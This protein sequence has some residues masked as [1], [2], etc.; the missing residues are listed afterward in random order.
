MKMDSN[1]HDEIPDALWERESADAERFNAGLMS[2]AEAK[3]CIAYWWGV[4]KTCG[5]AQAAKEFR[6]FAK[7]M[8]DMMQQE[9]DH[10]LYKALGERLGLPIYEVRDLVRQVQ[11]ETSDETET[12]VRLETETVS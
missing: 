2:E 8:A 12:G 4:A 11:G 6:G 5:D 10:A 7:Y 3:D 9:R 1:N